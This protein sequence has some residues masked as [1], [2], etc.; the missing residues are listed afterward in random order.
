MPQTS[1]VRD[2]FPFP[3]CQAR[4]VNSAILEGLFFER[5]DARFKWLR[6]P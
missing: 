3:I 4:D 2:E 5:F 6:F 1:L